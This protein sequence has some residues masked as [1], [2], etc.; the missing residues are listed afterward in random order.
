M[1]EELSRVESLGDHDYLIRLHQGGETI[2]IRIRASSDVARRAGVA[3]ADE[4]RLI[5]A[6]ASYLVA[7]QRAD[8]LPS[9][10]DLD[11]VAAAYDGYLGEMTAL[12]GR[13]E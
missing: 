2:E 1:T 10:L 13:R 4:V 12:L 8:D 7:R 6:T 3:D 5:E 11:D 9:S